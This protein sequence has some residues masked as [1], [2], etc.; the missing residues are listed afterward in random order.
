LDTFRTTHTPRRRPASLRVVASLALAGCAWLAFGSVASGAEA[1]SGWTQ[2]QGSALHVG[3]ATDAP[4]PPYQEAWNT[5]VPLGGPNHE[6]G[7]SA[8]V[9]A[10]DTVVSVAPEQIMGF[11]LQTGSSTFTV[12]KEL[13]PSVPPA[14]VDVGGRTA[15]VYTEGFGT[16]PASGLPTSASPSSGVTVSPTATPSATATRSGAGSPSGTGSPSAS[17]TP[18]AGSTQSLVAAFDLQTQKALW[19]PVALDEVSRTG[20]TV[21]GGLAYVGDDLGTVYAIDLAKGTI[22]WRASE[23]Q[24]LEAPVVVTGDLVIVTVP[25]DSRNHAKVVALKVAD[26]SEAWNYDAK[27]LGSVISGAAVSGGTVYAAFADDTVRALNVADGVLRWSSRVGAVVNPTQSPVV[28]DDAVYVVD[29]L[30]EIRRFHADSGARIWDYAINEF[31]Y[32]GSPVAAGDHILASTSKGRLVAVDPATGHLVWQ[33]DA[34]GSL[35]RSLTPT[36]DLILAVRGGTQPG[37]VAFRNDTGGALVDIVSPTVFDPGA[38]AGNF[39]LAV[40]PFLLVAILLGRFL[41]QRMGP[42][43][44]VEDDDGLPEPVDPWAA[45]EG[46]PE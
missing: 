35:L 46:E 1:L 31:V 32:R 14:L 27:T 34:S 43:F 4:E 16:E 6:F 40:V 8:P 33:S 28:T 30:G 41:S 44:I 37:L 17:G 20:V 22:A 36:S 10:G 24:P 45:E 11:D 9:V 2:A 42:A 3:V 23:G 38:F 13:G 7:L 12:P 25:G 5:S 26:G 19:P 29:V 21:D 18:P 15:V 39:A